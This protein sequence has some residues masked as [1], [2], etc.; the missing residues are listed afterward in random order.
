MVVG[1]MAVFTSDVFLVSIIFQF[2]GGERQ[3]ARENHV[4]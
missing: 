3:A 4:I 2:P 1:K